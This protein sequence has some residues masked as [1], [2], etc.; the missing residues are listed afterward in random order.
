M[1]LKTREKNDIRLLTC[2]N[3]YL[4]ILFLVQK[5]KLVVIINVGKKWNF[6]PV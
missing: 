4:S 5:K 2:N 1:V 6:L 3:L